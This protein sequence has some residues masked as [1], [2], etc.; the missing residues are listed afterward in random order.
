MSQ[1][2]EKILPLFF[3]NYVSNIP[4]YQYYKGYLSYRN[5]YK[6][7]TKAIYVVGSPEHDNLG[8]H[9]ITYAQ[10]NFLRKA[11]PDYTLIEIVANRLM[12]N[13]KCLE[14]F[15]SPE[16]IFV[17]QGGATSESSISVRKRY[18]ARLSPSSRIT[19]LSSSR[20]PST[21]VI[22]SWAVRSSKDTGPLRFP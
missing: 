18:A 5:A 13:M 20:R 17:L 8:D 1:A 16:D 19:K 9:A 11:F 2:L 3:R 7:K 21:S 4:V 10:M 6:D 22:P 14:E 12:H 15:C